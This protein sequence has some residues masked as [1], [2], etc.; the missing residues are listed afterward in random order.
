MNCTKLT[1]Q[2]DRR[3][4]EFSKQQVTLGGLGS[5]T[6]ARAIA[7]TERVYTFF[8]RQFQE[9]QLDPLDILK[10]GGLFGPPIEV[11]NRYLTPRKDAP[12]MKAVKPGKGVDPQGILEKVVG[13]GTLIHGEEIWLN[14]TLAGLQ[15]RASGGMK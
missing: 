1:H 2:H 14:I 10:D 8:E 12:H 6:F 3:R 13:A 9:D 15:W 4:I 5:P 11:S 7:A